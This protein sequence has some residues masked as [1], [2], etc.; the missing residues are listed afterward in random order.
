MCVEIDLLILSR[1]SFVKIPLNRLPADVRFKILNSLE[2]LI[3]TAWYKC[4]CS[5]FLDF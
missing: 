1:F 3:I 4:P 5:F 2:W